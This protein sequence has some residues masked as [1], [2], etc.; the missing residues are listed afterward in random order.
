MLV[1]PSA[2][3]P[4]QA[5][6][7]VGNLEIRPAELQVLVGERR[8][9]FTVREFEL[10][11]LLAQRLDTVVQRPEIYRL[12]WGG[13]MQRRNRSVDVLVRKVRGKLQRAAP[14]WRYIHTHFGIGYRFSPERVT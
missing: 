9:G 11:F 1:E 3:E 5:A 2:S 8:V 6:Y 7:R 14:D 10:F 13:E 12:M 4:V